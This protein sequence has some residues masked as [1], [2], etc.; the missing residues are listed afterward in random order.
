MHMS[1]LKNAI[2]QV[3]LA[4]DIADYIS[5][6]G[7]T[8]RPAG[9][10]KQKGLC[11]F[12]NE[13]TPSFTVDTHFQNYRCFGCGANGDIIKFVQAY[14]HLEFF[15]ALKKLAE[16]KGIDLNL[17]GEKSSIDYTSLRK[18][19]RSV[20]NFFYAEFKKLDDDHPAKQEVANRGL[21]SR[22]FLYGYAPNGR[23]TLYR[24]LKSE[25]FSDEVILQTGACSQY[26]KD[27]GSKTPISD[28]WR[29]RLMFYITDVTGKPIGWSGRKLYEDDQRGKYVN[30]RDGILFDKSA[31]LFNIDKAKEKAV[32][33]KTVYVNEGQF[34]VAAMSAAGLTNAV[35]SSGTA[36]TEKQ[37]LML[38][39]LVGED[40]RLIF[41]FDGDSAGRAAAQKV[42]ETVPIIHGQAYVVSL[43]DGYD[44]CDYRLENGDEALVQYINDNTVPLVEFILDQVAAGYDLHSEIEKSQYVSAA[45]RVLATLSS[46]VLKEAYSRHVSLI[47]FTSLDVVKG[48]AAKAEP[49]TKSRP[50][51]EEDDKEL[52]RPVIESKEESTLR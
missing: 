3:K 13:R 28:F 24:H 21:D 7:V 52:S 4:Y 5:S 2:A 25:G 12:H 20:A 26:T 27:D 36:F 51:A 46:N 48:A 41:C 9:V 38:R 42:F 6:S 17:D 8:L 15:D 37:G 30:S 10:N 49:I 33:D 32:A 35:A 34:D 45:A 47:S 40:G 18:A 50:V 23:Q 1:D 16:D 22:K 19:M 44:P 31:S 39:R 11:C 43:P 29:G 14:E